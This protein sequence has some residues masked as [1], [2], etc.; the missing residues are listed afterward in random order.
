MSI[1]RSLITI[2]VVTLFL[3]GCAANQRFDKETPDPAQLR[4]TQVAEDIQRSSNELA[5]IETAKYRATHKGKPRQ[6]DVSLLPGLEKSVSLGA[7]WNGPIDKLIDKLSLLAGLNPP[8]YLNVKPAGDV[9]VNVDTD[10]R[11]IIDILED[12]GA[13]TGQRAVITLKARERL[14]I[15]EYKTY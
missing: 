7:S 8:R 2:L 4:L 1:Y 13:Q 9:I 6:I 3:G 10:Y 12:V 15:V 14:L 11:P 5:A